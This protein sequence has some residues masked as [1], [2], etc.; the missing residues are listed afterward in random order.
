MIDPTGYRFGVCIGRG[1]MATVYRLEPTGAGP[2][3]AGKV[4]HPSLALD[5]SALE[6]FK[7]EATLLPGIDHPNLVRYHG[8]HEIEGRQALVMELVEGPSLAQVVAMEAPLPESRIVKLAL[9]IARGLAAAHDVGLIHRDLKPANILLDLDGVAKIAD[10]GM[11]RVSSFA[12]IDRKAFT[13]VGTPDYLAPESIDRL[14]VDQRADLYALGCI[15]FELATGEPPFAC[16]TA[17]ATLR[18]HREVPVADLDTGYGEAF[19]QLVQDLL[20][21]RPVQ[22]PPSAELVVERLKLL[23]TTRPLDRTHS[24]ALVQAGEGQ[25]ARS[26]LHVGGHRCGKCGADLHA[27]FPVC[28]ECGDPQ[29]RWETGPWS[30]YVTG[31]GETGKRFA[32]AQRQK[33]VDWIRSH[34]AL[35]LDPGR[36]QRRLPRAPL[37]LARGVSRPMAEQINGSLE[38]AGLECELRRGHP[39]R[40]KDWRKQLSASGEAPLALFGALLMV[41]FTVSRGLDDV[42]EFAVYLPLMKYLIFGSSLVG[43]LVSWGYLLFSRLSPRRLFEVPP[44]GSLHQ[45]LTEI[46]GVAAGLEHH[47][48]RQAFANTALRTLRLSDE[49]DEPCREE[50]TPVLEALLRH[51]LTLVRQLNE[52]D[53]KLRGAALREPTPEVAGTLATRDTLQARLLD[54]T[55]RLESARLRLVAARTRRGTGESRE[56]LAELAIALTVRE[57]VQ[58]P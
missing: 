3:L 36:H 54:L 41:G 14:A 7:R 39:L 50:L 33:I 40:S 12:G 42:R 35:G 9:D 8:L 53:R 25:P 49:L 55:A 13:I 38:D 56:L 6:R 28:F 4:I 57:E 31:P 37:L 11:A 23:Q 30:V 22:R 48:R 1:A 32:P 17:H 34:P 27:A 21:K 51:G 44:H 43:V 18:A 2:A 15:L 29:L 47:G 5:A 24:Q 19:R 10:F 58:R 26:T 52:L 16:N 20:A 45:V 46:S